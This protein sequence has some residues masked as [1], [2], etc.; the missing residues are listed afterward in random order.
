MGLFNK[1]IGQIFLKEDSD[2]ENFMLRIYNQK[3]EGATT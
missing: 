3:R 1:K 2:A